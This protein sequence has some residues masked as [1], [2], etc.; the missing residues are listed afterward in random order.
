MK[1]RFWQTVVALGFVCIMV[2][3]I[4]AQ[5][6]CL[7]SLPKDRPQLGCRFL[8]PFFD[9]PHVDL[10]TLSGI[11][12]LY[13]NI[14]VSARINLVGS[15]PFMTMD[16]KRSWSEF[17][18]DKSGI[19][20][21]HIGMQIHPAAGDNRSSNVAFGVFLPT[22]SETYDLSMLSMLTDYHSFYKYLPCDSDSG[23]DSRRFLG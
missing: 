9:S 23:C 19:G 3:S 18:Y 7:Q 2:G 6:F 10:S 5:T 16:Y 12:D 4:S 1:D 22:A 14:P 11:Y 8:H 17:G 20:N 15:I 13:A 21:I